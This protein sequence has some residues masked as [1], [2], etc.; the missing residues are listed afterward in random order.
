MLWA[1]FDVRFYNLVN[2][3]DDL[4]VGFGF[5]K[6]SLQFKASSKVSPF[7]AGLDENGE[8]IGLHSYL[9]GVKGLQDKMKSLTLAKL[10]VLEDTT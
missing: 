3:C 7:L 10:T 4:I 6:A 8:C 9:P 1:G 2:S 5:R